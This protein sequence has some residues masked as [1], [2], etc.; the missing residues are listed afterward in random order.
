MLAY[1]FDDAQKQAANQNNRNYWD[2][3]LQEICNQLGVTPIVL[4]PD[5]LAQAETLAGITVLLLG[6]ESS[7]ALSEQ[8]SATLT[9]WVQDG[10]IV[11]GFAVAGLD[12]LFGIQTIG[13]LAQPV[14]DYAI[15]A[16]IEFRLHALTREIHPFMHIEQ[17]LFALSELPL[18]TMAGAR[19]LAHL[20]DAAGNDLQH[21]AITWQPYGAGFAGYFA[22]DVAKTIWLLHQGK[23]LPPVP[24]GQYALRTPHLQVLGPNSTKVAYADEL[25]HLLQNMVAQSGLPFIYQIP[26]ENDQVP[27]ALL[28][29][30]GDEYT[31]PVELSLG[32]SDFMRAQGLGYHINIATEYHPMSVAELQH[33]Q[34]NGH[35]VSCYMWIRTEG[36]GSIL[37]QARLQ[38]QSDKLQERFGFRPGSVLIGSTQWAGWAEPA[39][40]L[41]QAGATADNTFVGSKFTVAHPLLNGPFFGFGNGTGYPFFFYDDA[42]HGNARIDLVEQPIVCYE[43]GHRASL[44]LAETGEREA[45][46]LA[47]EEVYT[48]LDRAIRYHLVMN[49][50]YHPYYIVNFPHCRAAIAEIVRYLAQKGAHVLHWGNN[51]AADWWHTRARTTITAV[52]NQAA[53]L[54]FTSNCAWPEGMIAKLLLRTPATVQAMCDGQVVAHTIKHEFGGD[55]LYVI[56]PAG[57]HQIQIRY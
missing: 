52:V 16:Y 34:A 17:R 39:R 51:K 13:A 35:E 28:Y 50:F 26:P 9:Q 44:T 47:L 43:V 45:D 12:P 20:Y 18:V 30:S 24:E 55:W 37:T 36:G 23:P 3:Y 10:G 8:A 1:L 5:Q 56:L 25:V 46:T 27:D 29:Y 41:A 54:T 22:F 6:C 49:I 53:A 7:K 4:A 40:W 31:G 42:A 48:P 14:D 32:A 57:E 21:P 38:V 19:E 11:I 33:I 2:V 15:V